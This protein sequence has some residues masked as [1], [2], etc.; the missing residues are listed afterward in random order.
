M[1]QRNL[2][3]SIAVF[4]VACGGAPSGLSVDEVLSIPDGTRTGSDLSGGYD[5]EIRVV[6]CQGACGPFAVGPFTASVCDVGEIDSD[7]AD[8]LHEG[9]HLLFDTGLVPSRYEGGVYA[10]GSFDVG[11]FAT[12]FGGELEITARGT[13]TIDGAGNIRA[14]V[15]SWTRGTVEGQSANCIGTREVTGT[16]N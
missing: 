16:R 5:I 15:E 6:D 2:P 9:G 1:N 10:D 4:V 14:V 7:Y 11:A 8:A 13:G 3:L 12:Q